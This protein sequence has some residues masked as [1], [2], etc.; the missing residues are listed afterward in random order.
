VAPFSDIEIRGGGNGLATNCSRLNSAA[1]PQH[2][3]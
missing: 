1:P 2:E 3:S